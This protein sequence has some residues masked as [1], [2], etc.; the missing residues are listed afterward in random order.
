L[1][2]KNIKI[3]IY[4]SIILPVALYGCETWSLTLREEYRLRGFK[5]R[6]L[7]RIFGPKRNEVRAKWRRLHNEELYDLHCSPNI[8]WVITSRKY[9]WVG[10]VARMGDRKG[11]Y[12][13]LVGRPEG[14]R[15]VG[16]PRRRWEDITMDLNE[17]GRKAWTGLNWLR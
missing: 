10:R 4:R 6:V 7:S 12:R 14:R 8:V 15:L 17:V 2:S 5:N 13:I 11:A 3:K 1:I 16:R 9:R